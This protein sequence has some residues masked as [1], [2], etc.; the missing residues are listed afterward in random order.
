MS[1]VEIPHLPLL[2]CTAQTNDSI[3]SLDSSERVQKRHAETRCSAIRLCYAMQRCVFGRLF[4]CVF[5]VFLLLSDN[6]T[7]G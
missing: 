2:Q 4:A 7:K 6:R 3:L 1:T 5:C